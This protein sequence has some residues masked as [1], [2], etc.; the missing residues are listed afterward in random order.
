M[1]KIFLA[2]AIAS[3]GLAC[4]PGVSPPI[5]SEISTTAYT[6]G[7]VV[8]HDLA[9]PE[10]DQSAKFYEAVFGWTTVPYGEGS[11]KVW[12]FQN[13]G[14]PVGLMAEY[15]TKTGTGEWIGSISVPDVGATVEMAKNKGAVV[16]ENPTVSESLG[17]ISFLQDAQ[18]AIISFVKFTNG[19][20]KPGLAK[21]NSFLGLELWSDNP[22][23]SIQ[24]Y[25]DVVGYS[26]EKISGMG[27][28]YTMLQKDDRNCAS[29]MKNPV[30]NVRSH[31]VPYIRVADI[32][33]TVSKVKAAGGKVLIE[34]SPEIRGGTAALFLDPTGAPVAIQV[35]N[36]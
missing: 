31:W 11:R 26:T 16:L 1:K 6:H 32:D 19:D 35:Y 13:E 9:S 33:A 18:G 15:K 23:A 21:M 2:L 3:F 7:K 34:P 4:T 24:F 20:P 36:P 12:V 28:D 27:I 25:T 22:A 5:A 10:P 8:W 30:E 17:T 29:I 14:E